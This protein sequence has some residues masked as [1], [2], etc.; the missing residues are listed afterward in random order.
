M[1][2]GP[3]VLPVDWKPKAQD[4]LAEII[5]YIEQRNAPAA[6]DLYQTIV[7]TAE[8]LPAMPYLFRRGRVPGTRECVVHPNYILIYQVGKQA[9]EVLRVLHSR[10]HYP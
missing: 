7:Q 2:N 5:D 8:N 4:D 6:Q 3:A 9:I 1:K 10:Q